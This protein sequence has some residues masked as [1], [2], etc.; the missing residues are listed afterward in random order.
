MADDPA[1][2]AAA[3]AKGAPVVPSKWWEGKADAITAG[4]L[5]NRGL[6]DKSPEE[7][8]LTVAKAHMEAEKY[9]GAPADQLIRLPK[10]KTDHAAWDAVFSKIGALKDGE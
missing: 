6:H 3:A 4:Y 5:Q 2:V 1:A 10:D 9:I 8:A 7:V